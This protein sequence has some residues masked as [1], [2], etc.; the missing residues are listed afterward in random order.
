MQTMIKKQGNSRGVIIPAALLQELG[1][2]ENTQVDLRV[3][4]GV[5]TITPLAPSLE[6]MLKG[7][8]KGYREA[9]ETWGADVGK[10]EV[11]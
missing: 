4:N 1:W 9:E 5:L 6:A 3:I 10:E 8:P 11:E 2:S 7:V